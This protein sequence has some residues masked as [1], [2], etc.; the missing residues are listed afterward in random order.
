M[1]LITTRRVHTHLLNAV[2]ADELEHALRF[3][4]EPVLES[5][6]HPLGEGLILHPDDL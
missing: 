1:L 6:K 4:D 2:Q 5:A 3:D